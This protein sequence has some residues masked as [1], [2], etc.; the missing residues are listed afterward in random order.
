[1][2]FRDYTQRGKVEK[3]ADPAERGA[4]IPLIDVLHRAL[5][6]ASDH[7]NQVRPV[8]RS[9]GVDPG[10]LRLVAQALSGEALERKGS[11]TTTAELTAIASLLAAWKRLVETPRTDQLE[12]S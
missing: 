7:P 12:L 9:S 6:L 5:A 10:Q 4:R 3:L 1:M 8:L 11:G 2:R